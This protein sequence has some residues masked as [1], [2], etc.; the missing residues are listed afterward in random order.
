MILDA[1]TCEYSP[2]TLFDAMG[3]HLPDVTWCDTETGEVEY[4]LRNSKGNFFTTAPGGPDVAKFRYFAK[5]PLRFVPLRT[6]TQQ[7]ILSRANVAA[8]QAA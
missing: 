7:E 2:C 1:K 8:L 3:M 5:A 4:Q 6:E